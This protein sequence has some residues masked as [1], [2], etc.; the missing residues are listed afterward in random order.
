VTQRALRY[1]DYKYVFNGGDL[2]ELYDLAADPHE[3]TN[4]APDPAHAGLLREM[5][6]RLDRWLVENNDGL[7]ERFRRIC[8]LV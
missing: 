5:R 8:D 4:L 1:R 3:L 6:L 2:E 7:S